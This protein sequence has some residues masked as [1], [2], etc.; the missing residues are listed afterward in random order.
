M[1]ENRRQKQHLKYWHQIPSAAFTE[2][3]LSTVGLKES[4][5][6]KRY[7]THSFAANFRPMRT[8]FAGCLDQA[9]IKLI[10][11]AQTDSVPGIHMLGPDAPELFRALQC[12]SVSVQLSFNLIEQSPL[13]LHWRRS[14]FFCDRRWQDGEERSI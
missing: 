13:L 8:A 2:P 14:L 1:E 6:V 3:P 7:A 11:G 12:H 10:V 9:F 5:S 4:Q